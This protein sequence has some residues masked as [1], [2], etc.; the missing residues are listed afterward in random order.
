MRYVHNPLGKPHKCEGCGSQFRD[1]SALKAHN[2]RPDKDQQPRIVI[3]P[4]KHIIDGR[5]VCDV[6]NVSL[7]SR[8]SL[9]MHKIFIHKELGEI[10][11]RMCAKPFPTAEDLSKHQIECQL[12]KQNK[13]FGDFKTFECDICKAILKS[14]DGVRQ[15]IMHTHL[16]IAK[17]FT[18]EQ[19]GLAFYTKSEVKLHHK[20]IHLNIRDFICTTCGKAFKLRYQLKNHEK[21][22]HSD[23]RYKC[24]Q[25]DCNKYFS[26]PMSRKKHMET[27]RETH[28]N[29]QEGRVKCELCGF[30]F[31]SKI[32]LQNHHRL[33]H[34][35]I[36]NF[37]CMVCGQ[38]LKSK[39]ALQL[40][41]Y[42]HTGEKPYSCP[43]EGCERKFRSQS[44]RDEHNRSHTGEKPYLCTV[45][46]CEQRFRFSV[47][48]RRHKQK[49]H[50]IE[51]I[52]CFP[53]TTCGE[54]LTKNSLLVKHMKLH[55]VR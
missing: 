49:I 19:C 26:T 1:I 37:K 25:D 20:I 5:F 31:A 52:K 6:C 33:T 46:G 29:P 10:V 18:C 24:F 22:V 41:T 9:R 28:G 32:T 39:L 16:K 35:N 50:G 15:H 53:C 4:K 17:R 7:G 36:R 30:S 55:A 38:A 40:H 14:K 13:N 34:L 44:N 2:C 3:D 8:T 12:K 45:D 42:K 47:D 21:F 54:V 11:C 48:F 27:H 51:S 23:E 43:H